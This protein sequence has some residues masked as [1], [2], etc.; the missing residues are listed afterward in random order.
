MWGPGV[1]ALLCFL[2]LKKTHRKTISFF[3]SS[4]IKSVVFYVVPI[5][6]LAAVGI[7]GQGMNNHL[8]P[9]VFGAIGFISILGEELGWRGYLQDAL[10]PLPEWK[11]Y[12]L[13]GTMWELWHFTNRMG[14]GDIE[15]IFVRVLIWISALTLLSF[16]IGKATERSQSVVVA[17]TL[18]AWIDI[19]AE[20]NE[21]AKFIVLGG[22]VPF[23]AYM[24]WRWGLGE[25]VR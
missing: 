14:H 15:Q 12:L 3:G 22:A 7:S 4:K 25:T 16:L 24:I 13:I 23:W 1:S 2:I 19:V 21:P 11:K 10:Q 9:I 5:L 17:V 20:F 8:F 6:A 18:H